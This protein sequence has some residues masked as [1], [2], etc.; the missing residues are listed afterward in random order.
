LTATARF[1]GILAAMQADDM[2]ADYIAN[3][4]DQ[5]AAVT[6]EDVRRVAARLAAT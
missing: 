3:R 6:V 2:P 1:A 5:V 4:N